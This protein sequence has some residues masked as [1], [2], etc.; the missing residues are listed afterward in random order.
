MDGSG[1]W[2][3]DQTWHTIPSSA[4]SFAIS[5]NGALRTVYAKATLDHKVTTCGG[6]TWSDGGYTQLRLL[7]TDGPQSIDLPIYLGS[8]DEASTELS[9]MARDTTWFVKPGTYSYVWQQMTVPGQGANVNSNWYCTEPASGVSTD[10]K[11]IVETLGP[12]SVD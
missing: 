6:T 1:R 5:P 4:F 8:G 7:Q 11:V 12:T 9:G 10:R 3:Y 2:T